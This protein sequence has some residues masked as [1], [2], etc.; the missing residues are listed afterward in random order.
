MLLSRS[1][2]E[3]VLGF[4]G[5]RSP[6]SGH[7][8]Q[9]TSREGGTVIGDRSQNRAPDG[10]IQFFQLEQARQGIEGSVVLNTGECLQGFASCSRIAFLGGDKIRKI[11]NRCWI[12]LKDEFV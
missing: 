4:F 11:V 1:L 12:L 10:R 6:I 5:Q 7:F 9:Q 2:C 8:L 3:G